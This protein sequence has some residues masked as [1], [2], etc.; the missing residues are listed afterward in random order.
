[1]SSIRM[2]PALPKTSKGMKQEPSFMLIWNCCS[3]ASLGPNRLQS[4]TALSWG[5]GKRLPNGAR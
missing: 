1:M 4:E 2:V 3:A 5:E